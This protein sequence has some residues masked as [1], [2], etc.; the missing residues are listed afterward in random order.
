VVWQRG[1]MKHTHL[2]VSEEM[3]YWRHYGK[4]LQ[5][6]SFGGVPRDI[7]ST[8]QLLIKRHHHITRV[9]SP[10]ISEQWTS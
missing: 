5:E 3:N 8:W 2:R 6:C 1:L 10:F 4:G 9:I 7:S